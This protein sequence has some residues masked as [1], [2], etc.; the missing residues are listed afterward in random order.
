LKLKFLFT[1][2][3]L[4]TI[5]LSSSFDRALNSFENKNYTLAYEK[6]YLLHTKDKEDIDITIYLAKS[7]Y[8]LGEY[9]DAIKKLY[10]IYINNLVH[11]DEVLLYLAKSYFN[12]KKYIESEKIFSKIKDKSILMKYLNI[13]KGLL[14]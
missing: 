5:L 8:Y 13:K 3:L 7:L 1:F 4:P 10:P 14:K 2:I 6:F 12:E 9:E 11:N